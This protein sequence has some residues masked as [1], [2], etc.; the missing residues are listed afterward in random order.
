M[1]L[2]ESL[3]IC[4]SKFFPLKVVPNEEG[5]GPQLSLRKYIFFPLEHNKFSE[6]CNHS[7]IFKFPDF[8]L[9]FQVLSKFPWPSTKFPDF[10]LTWKKFIV[11]IFF[12]D[13][14]NPGYDLI[15]VFLRMKISNLTVK[16]V[17][18]FK[19]DYEVWSR[20]SLL[21]F[22]HTIKECKKETNYT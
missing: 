22:I 11:Q 16:V 18:H 19:N 9:T 1:V 20:F 13:R 17:L 6:D 8:S 21:P 2:T 15:I 4:G 10:S 12:R 14:G 7:H 3:Q 5:D